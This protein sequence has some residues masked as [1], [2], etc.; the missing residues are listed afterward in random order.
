MRSWARDGWDQAAAADGK[1]LEV[2]SPTIGRQLL[3]R[4]L[5]DEI[6]LPLAP[7]L[8]GDGICLFDNPGGRP[9]RLQQPEPTTRSPRS[10]SDTAPSG[11]AEHGQRWA[12]RYAAG[13]R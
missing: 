5:L 2:M 10:A 3:E 8:L 7:V 9:I 12:H 4:G 11:R 6:D 1:N 13:S